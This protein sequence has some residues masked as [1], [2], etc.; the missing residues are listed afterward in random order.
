MACSLLV[1]ELD[2]PNLEE[3]IPGVTADLGSHIPI[4]LYFTRPSI[5]LQSEGREMEARRED[6]VQKLVLEST[7]CK[8]QMFLPK[9]I[10]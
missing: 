1:A 7:H 5:S 8:R 4:L 10:T 2:H 6:L 9:H 3:G